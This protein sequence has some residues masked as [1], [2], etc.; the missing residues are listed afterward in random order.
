MFTRLAMVA[1]LP[2]RNSTQVVAPGFLMTQAN[3]RSPSAR[4]TSI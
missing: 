3:C 4:G 1:E 2:C